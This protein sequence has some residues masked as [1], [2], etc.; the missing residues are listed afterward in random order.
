MSEPE[1]DVPDDLSGLDGFVVPDDLSELD[2]DVPTVAV[3]VTPVAVAAA[4]AAACALA[5]LDADAVPSP[6]GALAVLRD[7]GAGPAGA[8]DVSRLL[9]Q[10]PVVLLERRESRMS[11]TQW[12][13]GQRTRDLPPGLVLSNAPQVLEELLLDGR[14]P[15]DIEGVVT[16]VGISRF[17]AMRLLA[18][19]RP[20]N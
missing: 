13:A 15:A 7:S 1:F 17:Q 3:V 4:L 20:R 9:G 5:K 18:A 16:S 11:A 6:A 8:A 2:G 19:N 12:V 14:A 10:I